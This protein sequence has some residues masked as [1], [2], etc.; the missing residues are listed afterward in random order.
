MRCLFL[1]ILLFLSPIGIA[2]KSFTDQFNYLATYR[3]TYQLDST[4]ISSKKSENMLLYLGKESSQFSSAGTAAR[5]QILKAPKRAGRNSADFKRIQAATPNTSI[6][7]TIYKHYPSSAMSFTESIA[8]EDFRY[9]QE[10]GQLLW[11]IGMEQKEINGYQAQKATA[12][13][14]GRDYVAWF[15]PEIPAPDGP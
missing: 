6:H 3:Y 11:K 7:Y 12:K 5:E 1:L 4:D 10:L 9:S 2:Q 13:F 8:L 14:A 15:T